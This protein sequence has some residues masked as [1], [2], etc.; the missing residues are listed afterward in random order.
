MTIL[1]T[2]LCNLRDELMLSDYFTKLYEYA[3]VIED[4]DKSYP[5]YYIGNG[6]YK[7]I[8]DFDTNGS[9][10]IRKRGDISSSVVGS[11]LQSCSDSNPMLDITVPLRLVCAVP[12]KKLNDNGFSDD[13]LAFDLIGYIGRR[14]SAVTGAQSVTGRVSSYSTDRNEIWHEEVKGVDKQVDLTLSFIAIEFTLTLRANLDC[15]K[16][17][18]NY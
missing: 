11:S 12:K 10:Y 2:A 16:Q 17:N 1:Q 13:T 7:R 18:C 15:I 3:E 8:Y 14:Q 5:Q 4:G 9:G 6:S